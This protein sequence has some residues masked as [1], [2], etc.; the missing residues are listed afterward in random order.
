MPPPPTKTQVRPTVMQWAGLLG[1]SWVPPRHHSFHSG[2][3]RWRSL[4]IREPCSAS[5]LSLARISR[6]DIAACT[7][8]KAKLLRAFVTILSHN[9]DARP[10]IQQAAVSCI[11]TY[12]AIVWA[13]KPVVRMV[14]DVFLRTAAKRYRTTRPSTRRVGAMGEAAAGRQ[15]AASHTRSRNFEFGLPNAIPTGL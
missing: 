4:N 5:T 6:V 13:L 12:L 15:Y 11:G 9:T 14:M 10:V 2:R 7:V 1:A 8:P 3:T